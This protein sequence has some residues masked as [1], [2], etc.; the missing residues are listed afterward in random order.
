MSLRC[1]QGVHRKDVLT[2]NLPCRYDVVKVF[3][4]W[5]AGIIKNV[6]SDKWILA[7]VTIR[8][9]ANYV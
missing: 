3:A 5:E 9:N 2:M 1:L 6:G 7:Y 4:H 8:K